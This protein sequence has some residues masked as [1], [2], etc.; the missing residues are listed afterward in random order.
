MGEQIALGLKQCWSALEERRTAWR[1]S[2]LL[3]GCSS[4]FLSFLC[5]KW[6]TPMEAH[7]IL[8]CASSCR[9]PCIGSYVTLCQVFPGTVPLLASMLLHSSGAFKCLWT[10]CSHGTVLNFRVH[11]WLRSRVTH[12]RCRWLP[13]LWGVWTAHMRLLVF[14]LSSKLLSAH[15][16]VLLIWRAVPCL[17]LNPSEPLKYCFP[18]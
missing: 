16:S 14:L 13:G 9:L 4:A 6:A 11:R 10:D 7:H 1:R 18:L 8:V 5:G 3:H 17:E 2:S 12:P 15:P